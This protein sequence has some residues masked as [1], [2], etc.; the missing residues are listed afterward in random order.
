MTKEQLTELWRLAATGGAILSGDNIYMILA[1]IDELTAERDRLR[2]IIQGIRSMAGSAESVHRIYNVANA[3][4]QGD[5][6]ENV[7]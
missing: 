4:L 3:A 1:H 5:S 7:G 6:D 2:E